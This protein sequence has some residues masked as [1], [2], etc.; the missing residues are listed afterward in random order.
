MGYLNIF[1]AYEDKNGYYYRR[2]FV[3]HKSDFYSLVIFS[4]CV[5]FT[6]HHIVKRCVVENVMEGASV[7][8]RNA[9]LG[10]ISAPKA[11]LCFIFKEFEDGKF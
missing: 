10:T 11:I 2:F 9:T 4:H 8:T 5:M 7:H 3:T 1:I 6:L